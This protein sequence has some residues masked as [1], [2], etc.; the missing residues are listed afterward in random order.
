MG[1]RRV[2]GKRQDRGSKS[3]G[4]GR[5]KQLFNPLRRM[6]RKG[7]LRAGAQP[8]TRR[9]CRRR[10]AQRCALLCHH[11]DY[12]YVRRQAAHGCSNCYNQHSL[13]T[14]YTTTATE[15]SRM[16]EGM[17][18]RKRSCPAV[19]LQGNWRSPGASGQ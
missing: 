3:V 4:K 19:S 9:D 7:C 1:G 18:E 10:T 5:A 8:C 14:S 15:E 13:V 11:A 6:P 16:Y 17:S 12:M 2:K